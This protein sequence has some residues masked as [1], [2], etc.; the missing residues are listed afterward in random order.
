MIAGGIIGRSGLIQLWE[1][2]IA[3]DAF[4]FI[5]YSPERSAHVHRRVVDPSPSIGLIG[6][7]TAHPEVHCQSRLS[8]VTHDGGVVTDVPEGDEIATEHLAEGPRLAP[9]DT[10]DEEEGDALVSHEGEHGGTSRVLDGVVE[11]QNKLSG[12]VLTSHK[13]IIKV[14]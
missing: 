2:Y 7:I 4:F 11:K 8:Q 1:G 5:P 13:I 14:V 9:A 3:K 12:Q 6:Q 10:S